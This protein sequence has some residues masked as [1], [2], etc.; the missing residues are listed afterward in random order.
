MKHISRRALPPLLAGL[1]LLSVLLALC[2]GSV[3][4]PLRETARALLA[5]DAD[6]LFY[7]VFVHVR[8]PRVLAALSAGMALSVSGVLLQGVFHN[9]L[10]G[11]NIIGVNAG[12]GF[13]VMLT[14][15]LLPRSALSVP[16]AGFL[17]ALGAALLIYLIA[18]LSG[19]DNVTVVLTGVAV[20][21]LLTAGMDA[22]R[23]LFPD[24]IADASA[25]LIGSFG[26]ASMERLFPAVWLILA[27]LA[28][29]LLTGR[30]LDVL[31]LGDD[32][33]ASLGMDV[34]RARFFFLLIAALLA[35]AAVSF[36][37][38]LGFVGLLVPHAVRRF[39]G[40]S[41]A[42]LLPCAALAGGSF[43]VLCDLLGRVLFAP[44]ELPAG[45]LLSALGAPFFLSLLLKRRGTNP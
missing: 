31:A 38:L 24:S 37:G 21:S 14:V 39:T 33:A 16:A 32:A 12:A 20:A 18:S 30:R 43:V 13:A 17:G 36:A 28:A 1:V 41:H 23:T 9:V 34:G 45:V 5:G 4:L 6:S 42:L 10:A 26:G 27:G 19:A 2:A 22:L 44:Y 15:T 35:G 29:A 11:P 7:R 8:L 25:F 3:T 40:H